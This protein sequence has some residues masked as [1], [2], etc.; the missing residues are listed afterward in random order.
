MGVGGG[1]RSL[2][3]TKSELLLIPGPPFLSEEQAHVYVQQGKAL[4]I[5]AD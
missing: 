1:V 5:P 4:P 2:L 3:K